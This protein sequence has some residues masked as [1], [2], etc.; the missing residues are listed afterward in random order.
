MAAYLQ[1]QDTYTL[2]KQVRRRFPRNITYADTVDACWQADLAD[3]NSLKEDNDGYV[4]VLCVNDVFSRYAWTIPLKDKKGDT[5]LH[6][7]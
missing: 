2:H 6:A 4:F 3:F 5:V 7:F 1:G